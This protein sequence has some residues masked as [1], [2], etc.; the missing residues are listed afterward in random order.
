MKIYVSQ[1]KK[2]S[3]LLY[4]FLHLACVTFVRSVD[5]ILFP[6]KKAANVFHTV[7]EWRVRVREREEKNMKKFCKSNAYLKV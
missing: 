5:E 7:D 2:A 1:S 4:I 3:V 6:R